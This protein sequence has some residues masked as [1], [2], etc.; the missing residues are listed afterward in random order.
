MSD[1]IENTFLMTNKGYTG[2][3]TIQC[4]IH[5]I[6]S[7][8]GKFEH[9]KK[10]S[11]KECEGHFYDI[12]LQHFSNIKSNIYKIFYTMKIHDGNRYYDWISVNDIDKNMYLSMVPNDKFIVPKFISELYNNAEELVTFRIDLDKKD[13]WYMLGYFFSSNGFI[14]INYIS[15]TYNINFVIR[16]DKLKT[17]KNKFDKIFNTKGIISSYYDEENTVLAYS[18]HI[19]YY[20]IKELGYTTYNRKVPE[21]IQNAPKIFIY[22]FLTGYK[23]AKD[24]FYDSSYEQCVEIQRLYLK[25]GMVFNINHNVITEGYFLSLDEKNDVIFE[26]DYIWCP[27]KKISKKISKALVYNVEIENSSLCIEN[28]IVQR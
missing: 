3:E 5:K 7:I 28:C 16:N 22:S 8:D 18:N 11:K 20:I 24:S 1:I 19:W 26:K 23:N 13:Y 4:N 21:W 6:I 9:I 10:I 27:I 14:D 2:I 17:I 12:K 15:E 25:I